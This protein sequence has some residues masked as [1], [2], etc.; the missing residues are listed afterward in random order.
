M[1]AKE[2]LDKYDRY[3]ATMEAKIRRQ[4]TQINKR[5]RQ[6]LET[7]AKEEE[8]VNFSKFNT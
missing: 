4:K 7:L 6:L 2:T 8:K 1:V 5:A 3:V